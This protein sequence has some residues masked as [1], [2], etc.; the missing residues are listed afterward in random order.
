MGVGGV[1]PGF[2]GYPLPGHN[3]PLPLPPPNGLNQ[4]SGL[5][6]AGDGI[7]GGIDG[8]MGPI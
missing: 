3:L 2:G 8:G 6:A 5:S 1:D 4:F 7:K